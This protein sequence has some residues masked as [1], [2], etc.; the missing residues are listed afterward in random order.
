[1]HVI[2]DLQVLLEHTRLINSLINH[3]YTLVLLSRKDGFL[4]QHLQPDDREH[5]EIYFYNQLE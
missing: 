3:A 4:G 2:V 5:T 1:M